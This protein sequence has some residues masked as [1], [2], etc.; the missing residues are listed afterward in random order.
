MM[1][2]KCIINTAHLGMI[3]L[4]LTQTTKAQDRVQL[5]DM[6]PINN[7]AKNVN[8]LRI[9]LNNDKSQYIRFMFWNQVWVRHNENNPGT[10]VNNKPERFSTD[11]ILRRTRGLAMFNLS[12]RYRMLIHAGMNNQ[13]FNSGGLNTGT[14][15]NGAGRRPQFYVHDAYNEY[16]LVPEKNNNGELNE[17]TLVLGAGLH[18]WNG[19]SRLYSSTTVASLTLDAMPAPAI[20]DQTD[21][22]GRQL[23][24][25][26]HGRWND[27]AF[28]FAI[29]KPFA[30]DLVAE[31]GGP[32]VDNNRDGNFSYSGYVTYNF[33][34]RERQEYSAFVQNYLGSKKIFNIGAGFYNAAN[35]TQTQPT[36][37][38]FEN[39]SISIVGVDAF[40]DLPIGRRGAAITS[41][42]SY[43]N[44][45][46]GPNYLRNLGLI[47]PGL[48][49]PSFTGQRELGFGNS[50]IF[51]G[52][53]D[54][55]YL[56]AGYLFPNF[57]PIRLQP[58]ASIYSRNFEAVNERGN[59]YQAGMNFLID[60]H[61]TKIVFQYEN[62]P[63]F[64]N[65]TKYIFRRG[66]EYVLGFQIFF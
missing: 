39:H 38:N 31:V 28:R 20:I 30:A 34:E 65:E 11:V 10:I 45:K 55:W 25:F 47:N 2:I 32:A 7:E 15:P 63:M 60:N 6:P 50:Q 37:G 29:N 16:S 23:G 12:P 49:D 40:L 4:T 59:S 54:F 46:L 64:D 53:G 27:I 43:T 18:A 35:A 17:F 61:R 36:V 56:Q 21:Q 44:S 42:V 33:L 48:E 14:G 41:Y 22:F 5:S 3:I 66:S 26:T 24:V 13:S 58:F 62:R 52:T 57:L 1:K 9:D 51:A 8:E 19:V